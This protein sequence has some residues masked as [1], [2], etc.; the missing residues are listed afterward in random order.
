MTSTI[1]GQNPNRIQNIVIVGGGTS[2]WLSAAYLSKALN[3]SGGN[4]C[5]ITLIE[6]SD[7]CTVGVGEATLPTLIYTLSDFL[8][9]PEPDWMIECNATFKLGIKF[10]NWSGQPDQNVFWH[11]FGGEDI[12][13]D[14]LRQGSLTKELRI[15]I[16]H[17]WLKRKLQGNPEPFDYSCFE[18]V[19][20]CAAKKSPKT[21]G[22]PKLRSIEYAYHLDAGLLA[23]YLKRK[24]KSESV[25]H[26]VDNVLDVSLNEKGFISHLTTENNGNIYGDLF[27]D[28]SGF[29]GLLINQA[30]Q[31]PFISY[32][33]SLFCDNAIAIPMAYDA[34]DEY[35]TRNGGINP[36]TT[37]TALSSGWAWNTPL[38]GRS[39]NGYV[40]SS[41][42]ISKADAEA[43]FRQHLGEKSLHLEAKH[44]KMRVGRTRNAWVK[45]CISI[46]LSSGFIEP[47]ESTGIY[48]IEAGLENLLHN[49]PDRLFQPNCIENYNRIMREQYEEIRDFIVMHYCLTKREDTPFWQANK[50]HPA[51]PESL[52][53]KLKLWQL[54]WPDNPTIICRQK[55]AKLFPDYS[56]TCILAG[57][58]HFPKHSLPILDYYDDNEVE[59]NFLALKNYADALKNAL[60]AHHEYIK[61]LPSKSFKFQW[62]QRLSSPAL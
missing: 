28:C 2:G 58:G 20:L 23:N 54:T 45:N 46:G 47:L 48:L 34:E 7:I 19:H 25:K 40:Y 36:Y 22:N 31:E 18:S 30:L 61:Q 43:E 38:V 57:M 10:V 21:D 42:F 11:P 27:I 29:K 5:T 32:S 26:I 60:P 8:G 44:I 4:P 3:K 39:G 6:S 50:Y 13:W 15:P 41:A 16:S 55:I 52:K 49:F 17:Y 24:A 33:D 37:A 56:Y 35:D 12:F 62:K 53:E 51:I 9:I 14:P 1:A 59:Q